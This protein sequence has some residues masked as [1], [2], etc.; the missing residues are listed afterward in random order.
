VRSGQRNGGWVGYV[1]VMEVGD[2]SDLNRSCEGAYLEGERSPA[3]QCV[4]VAGGRTFV[5]GRLARER[6]IVQ[7]WANVCFLNVYSTI[8]STSANDH[9]RMGERSLP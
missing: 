1:K 4:C 2:E 8:E 6:T 7:C 5:L 9:P 3:C